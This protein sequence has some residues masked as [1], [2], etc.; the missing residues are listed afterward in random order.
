MRSTFS[1]WFG[2]SSSKLLNQ[3]TRL[4]LMS[5]CNLQNKIASPRFTGSYLSA[6]LVYANGPATSRCNISGK[7]NSSFQ[8]PA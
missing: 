6:Y 2:M 3:L 1:R 7:Q 8:N 5:I 4:S